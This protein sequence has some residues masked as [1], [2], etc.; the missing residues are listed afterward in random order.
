[1]LRIPHCHT[2]GCEVV[3][4]TH[5]P[6]STPQKHYLSASGAHFCQWLSKPLGLVRLEGLGKLKN[7]SSGLKPATL[8]LVAKYLNQLRYRVPFQPL[9]SNGYCFQ[10]HHLA[11]TVV[12]LLILRLL[13]SKWS[14]CYNNNDTNNNKNMT[15]QVIYYVTCEIP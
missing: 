13:P 7:K 6:R 12:Q 9:H 10:R 15:W 11:T 5:R 2:D 4:L 3:S 14:I 1:M 8:R